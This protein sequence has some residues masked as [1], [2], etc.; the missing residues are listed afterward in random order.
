MEDDDASK[1]VVR[2]GLVRP[3]HSHPGI[4]DGLRL[5]GANVVSAGLIRRCGQ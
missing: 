3:V 2:M 1:Y 5:S 4:S